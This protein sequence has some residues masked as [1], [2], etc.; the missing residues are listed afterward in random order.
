MNRKLFSFD[1]SLDKV[2]GPPGRERSLVRRGA[3]ENKGFVV[4]N[5]SKEEAVQWGVLGVNG[6]GLMVSGRIWVWKG[7]HPGRGYRLLRANLEFGRANI[8]LGILSIVSVPPGIPE[9]SL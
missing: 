7:F 4:H 3:N 6:G 8:A 9:E 2:G 1:F 5:E